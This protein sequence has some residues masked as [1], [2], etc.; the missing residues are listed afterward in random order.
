MT[1][2]VP[3]YVSGLAYNGAQVTNIYPFS[4]DGRLLHD[5]LLFTGNGTPLRSLSSTAHA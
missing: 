3:Q 1:V 4:R 5:V 2:E